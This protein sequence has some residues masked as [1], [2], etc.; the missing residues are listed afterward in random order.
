MEYPTPSGE[1]PNSQL[2]FW[3]E[4][5][6]EWTVLSTI[7]RDQNLRKEYSNFNTKD[8]LE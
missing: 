4:K 3:K 1:M 2:K 5:Y 7:Y 8:D 6:E